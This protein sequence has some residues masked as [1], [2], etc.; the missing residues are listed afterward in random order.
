MERNYQGLI[1]IGLMSFGSFVE[2]G[3]FFYTQ[4]TYE[5]NVGRAIYSTNQEIFNN[6]VYE[7]QRLTERGL[8][9]LTMAVFK[10]FKCN[11]KK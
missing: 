8:N 7:A 9:Q 6:R 1:A 10:F 4:M 3:E 5:N 2:H 11:K